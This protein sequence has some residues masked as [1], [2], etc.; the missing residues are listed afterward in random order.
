MLGNDFILVFDKD[1]VITDTESFKLKL[2]ENLLIEEF[3]DFKD[4]IISC[5]RSHRGMFRSVKIPLIFQQVLQKELSD[6]Q[7]N[8][9][10][11]K[12][13]LK[14]K[15]QLPE[16]QLITGVTAFIKQKHGTQFISSA[17]PKEEVN[18]HIKYFGFQSYFEGIYAS[19]TYT[20]KTLAL[21]E[22]KRTYKKEVIFFGDSL[23]D[24][25]HAKKADVHFVGI[26]YC[27]NAFDGRDDLFLLSDFT[28]AVDK[29]N[30][31]LF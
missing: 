22:I 19:P 12:F 3:P 28:Q 14:M 21:Q 10:L 26:T 5:N 30:Q 13:A 17:A 27:S 7:L 1:G 29:I 16:V 25:E 24:L 11:E 23:S 8:S 15:K 6:Q 9:Y 4:Q 31:H 2:L 20:N 18:E